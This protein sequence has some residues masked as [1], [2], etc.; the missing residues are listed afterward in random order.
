MWK[1]ERKQMAAI[2]F[3]ISGFLFICGLLFLLS[4]KKPGF[5]PPR[6]LLK[7]RA[8]TSCGGGAIFLIIGMM[9]M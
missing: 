6:H 2:A 4:I 9:M 8:M 5:Y 1:G 7:R 3:I